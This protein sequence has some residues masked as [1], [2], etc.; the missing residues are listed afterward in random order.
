MKIKLRVYVVG[1]CA[2]HSVNYVI[3]SLTGV[4]DVGVHNGGIAMATT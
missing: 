3:P 1:R 4:L 2:C